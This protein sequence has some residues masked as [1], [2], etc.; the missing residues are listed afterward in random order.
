MNILGDKES[1]SGIESEVTATTDSEPPKK[2]YISED[3]NGDRVMTGKSPKHKTEYV[4]KI[5]SPK[6]SGQSFRV[7]GPNEKGGSGTD[8]SDISGVPKVKHPAK[9]PDIGSITDSTDYGYVTWEHRD[10]EQE[11]ENQEQNSSSSNDD[12]LRRLYAILIYILFLLPSHPFTLR[13]KISLQQFL[14]A[15]LLHWKALC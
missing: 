5:R 7:S 12:D 14:E 3:N 4:H 10:R 9:L 15:F 6:H 13:C 11:Q 8:S 2:V 1:T